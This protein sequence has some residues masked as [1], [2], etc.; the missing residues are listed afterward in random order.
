MNFI[1]NF[2]SSLFGEKN[3]LKHLVIAWD[4]D[5]T[6]IHPTPERIKI[7][8]NGKFDLQFW[9]D[10]TT[11]E[12]I[13]KDTLLPLCDVFYAYQKAGFTQICVTARDL[14]DADYEYFKKHNLNFDVILHRGDS[15]DLD[16]LLKSKRLKSFFDSYDMIPFEY[17]DDKQ[18]NLDVADE[19]GFRT[20]H[21]TYMNEKLGKHNLREINF[22]PKEFV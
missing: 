5:G 2:F 8:D 1:C 17:W 15:Q 14:C 22:R 10:H 16:Q 20:F 18:E 3:K 6:L 19:F 21:A 11:R 12:F 9:I 7:D 13:M 4:L